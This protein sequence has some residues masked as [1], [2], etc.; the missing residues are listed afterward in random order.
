MLAD[1]GAQLKVARRHPGWSEQD[2][3]D[4]WRAV[5]TRV[6]APRAA[7]PAVWPAVRGVGVSGQMHGAVLLDAARQ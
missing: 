7:R 1:A 5:L 4:W 3:E 6:A 2:P